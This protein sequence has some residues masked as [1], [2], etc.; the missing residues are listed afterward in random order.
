VA[1]IAVG[2][3]EPESS[4]VV[5]AIDAAETVAHFAATGRI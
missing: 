1:G 5:V 3:G 4:D 2:S